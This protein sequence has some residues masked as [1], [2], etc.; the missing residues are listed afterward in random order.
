[1]ANHCI[2]VRVLFLLYSFPFL[3]DSRVGHRRSG[4]EDLVAK[5]QDAGRVGTLQCDKPWSRCQSRGGQ[6]KPRARRGGRLPQPPFGSLLR[7]GRSSLIGC[8]AEALACDWRSA[9]GPAA[10]APG[11]WAG[12]AD[13]RAG[14]RV[15]GCVRAAGGSWRARG[16]RWLPQATEAQRAP[17][18]PCAGKR[19]AEGGLRCR[20]GVGRG[21]C[22]ERRPRGQPARSRRRGLLPGPPKLPR[23]P[24]TWPAARRAGSPR[25]RV[26][27]PTRAP[28]E[29]SPA[30][31][32]AAAPRRPPPLS[33]PTR[34]GGGCGDRGG[35][36][37]H[38]APGQKVC[39]A[40]VCPSWISDMTV[41]SSR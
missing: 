18:R 11:R 16:Q 4:F 14:R 9:L 22:G 30:S 20:P 8:A 26:A 37:A 5:R 24:H 7:G 2:H 27:R 40:L 15:R 12:A 34:G 3:L 1:M 21:E 41:L 25:T 33:V 23:T 29:G 10:P 32:G 35:R 38:R 19:H 6:A 17:P 28:A 39:R 13:R 31:S 36:R